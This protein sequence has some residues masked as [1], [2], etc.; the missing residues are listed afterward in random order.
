MRTGTCSHLQADENKPFNEKIQGQIAII[1]PSLN[2]NEK[3]VHS[4]TYLTANSCSPV[5]VVD[6]GSGKNYRHIFDEIEKL[7]SVTL[8][9]HCVNLGKGRALKT[10]FNYCIG[11]EPGIIGAV[12]A[13]ADGQHLS[14]DIFNIVN[15]LHDN[16]DKLIMGCRDFSGN[17]P[18]KSK[19]GN[20]FTRNFFA[21]VCGG[22]KLSDTQTGLRGIPLSLMKHLMNCKGERFEFE[23]QMLLCAS[24]NGFEFQSV[25][26]VTVYQNNNRETHF[27]P[28]R[29]SVRIYSVLLKKLFV[30]FTKFVC[31]SISSALI[32]IILFAFMYH[33]VCPGLGIPELF[34]STVVARGVSSFF[35]YNLNKIFVFK[36]DKGLFDLK[37]FLRYYGLCAF[38]L[39]CSYYSVK[40]AMTLFPEAEAVTVKIVV[41]LI[42]FILTFISQ[43]IFVFKLRN[44]E[45]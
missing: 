9:R 14:E 43:K 18:W 20:I 32:D 34:C 5:I 25:P 16:P 12:T 44:W 23:T 42:L 29:D 28:F 45:K 11:L 27:D 3:L 39:L 19:I 2:P 26:I 38:V 1:I 13:D 33:I 24:D 8:L 30:Q 21:L 40:A 35:N 36:F 4:V 10:A 6:D 15:A 37:S 41:D 31:C 22:N 17:V 7:P